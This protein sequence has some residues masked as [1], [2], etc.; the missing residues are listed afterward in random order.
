MTTEGT[1]RTTQAS[2]HDHDHDRVLAVCRS[3]W[4]YRG[5]DDA[6]VREMLDELSAH[7]RDAEAA[8]RTARDV[9]G[10]DVP[11]FAAAWARGRTPLHRRALRLA[12]MASFTVGLLWLLRHLTRWT[13]ELPVDAADLAF[14]GMIATVTVAWEL[15]RGSL[16]LGKGWL[17]A[18][19]VGLPAA[20]LTRY[21]AGDGVL[22]TLPVWA[23]P[24]LILPAVP[25]IVADGRARK[26]A[27]ADAA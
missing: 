4:E 14:W 25:Y 19:A 13:A 2:D 18:F 17:L 15:R 11:A 6:S 20:L 10:D 22:F 27:A 24:L 12:A 1:T 3:N 8:G 5:V 16:G 26:A 7:L 9:V 23:A 21:L